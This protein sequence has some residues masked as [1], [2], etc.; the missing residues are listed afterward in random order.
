[1]P[2]YGRLVSALRNGPE[3]TVCQGLAQGLTPFS[4][5]VTILPVICS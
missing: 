1:M 5:A 4:R 2:R 3:W